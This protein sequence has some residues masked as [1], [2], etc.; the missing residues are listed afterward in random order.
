[1][2]AGKYDQWL[3]FQKMPSP[4][5]Q[6]SMGGSIGVPVTQFSA[7]GAFELI[8]TKEFPEAQKRHA[9][10][11]ARFRIPYPDFSIDPAR[12]QIAQVFDAEI[13]PPLSATWNVLGATPVDGRR[14]EMLIEVSEIR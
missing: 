3:V 5:P 8:G 10:T 6:D 13:S 7:W 1:M 4:E 11:T 2:G 12:H 9:E 14:F